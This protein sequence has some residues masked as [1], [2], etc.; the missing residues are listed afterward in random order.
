[1]VIGNRAVIHSRTRIWPE[2]VVPDNGV[3]TEHLLNEKYD[4]RCE[5]S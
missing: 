2:V 3:V 1:V 4:S 5:G